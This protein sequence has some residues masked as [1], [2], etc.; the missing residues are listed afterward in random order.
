MSSLP[1]VCS[2]K[3][4]VRLPRVCRSQGQDGH[5][6]SRGLRVLYRLIA[7]YFDN[8]QDEQVQN[9]LNGLSMPF[10]ESVCFQQAG[11]M[12]PLGQV[13]ESMMD[14]VAGTNARQFLPL[15]YQ[16]ISRLGEPKKWVP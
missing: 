2:L 7:L 10:F 13:N 16:V 4:L 5:T 6:S 1:P 14:I 9:N 8:E 12:R 11:C 15:L 3:Y